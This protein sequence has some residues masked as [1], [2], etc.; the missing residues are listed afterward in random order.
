MIGSIEESGKEIKRDFFIPLIDGSL[1][2]YD[3]EES[4]EFGYFERTPFNMRDSR[5]VDAISREQCIVT[6]ISKTT[7]I[8]I[9]LQTGEILQSIGDEDSILPRMR[10]PSDE[11]FW[12]RLKK[13]EYLSYDHLEG[14]S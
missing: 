10:K 12:M 8:Q 4:S 14:V 1:I 11:P 13:Y 9:D 2:R 5:F 3:Q 6:G 7:A